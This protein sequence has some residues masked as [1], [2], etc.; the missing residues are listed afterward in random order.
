MYFTSL[1]HNNQDQHLIFSTH[2]Y[3]ICAFE[4]DTQVTKLRVKKGQCMHTY[5]LYR[6]R[7]SSQSH[8]PILKLSRKKTH[9]QGVFHKCSQCS[10][11]NKG[12]VFTCL[13]LSKFLFVSSGFGLGSGFSLIFSMMKQWTL[14]TAST[15]PIIRHTLSVVPVKKHHH[16]SLNYLSLQL[17][18]S[19]PP[20]P[21]HGHWPPQTLNR[22]LNITQLHINRSPFSFKRNLKL[23]NIFLSFS[24]EHGK[25]GRSK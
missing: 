18:Q 19:T 13:C 8:I 16:V 1:F 15:P 20:Q 7:A 12:T 4:I 5:S 24:F 3:H 6:Y 11:P 22:C 9:Y 2:V 21:T 17:I 23:R 14:L 10:T 25:R